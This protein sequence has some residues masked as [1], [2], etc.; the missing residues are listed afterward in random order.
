MGRRACIVG[1]GETEFVRDSDRTAESFMAEAIALALADA[2]LNAREVQGLAV[3]N[4]HLPDDSAYTAEHLGFELDWVLKGDQGGAA[5]IIS[6]IRARH[7]IEAGYIDIAVCAAGDNRALAREHDVTRPLNDYSRRN[8]V[9]PY[10]YGG[11]N[12][13]FALVQR[14]H[15]HRYGTTAE[16]LGKIAVTFRKHAGLNPNALL[17]DPMT[18][19]DYL[20]SRMISDPI[21]LFD[22]VM[23]CCGGDAVVVAAEDVAER[24]GRAPVYIGRG[25]ERINY[26][27][28]ERLPDKLTMGFKPIAEKMLGPAD[29]ARVD[30]LQCYDDYPIAILMTLEDLG[31]CRKGV[32]GAFV[33]TTDLSFDGDLPM[34]TGGGQLS[35]GQPGL[36]GGYLHVVEAVRQLRGEAG[37]RQVPEARRG[38]VTGIGLLSYHSNV[39]A[40]AAVILEGDAS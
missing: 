8:F 2:G 4:L 37:A 30:F 34:N 7:A 22:C 5:A 16:Q 9:D 28:R 11:P 32:G 26:Q 14:L 25:A 18:I 36:A 10:G 3:T 31:Y 13:L 1:V 12:S 24:L 15:M 19:D 33:E 35:A 40:N 29:R 38:L 27:I 39:A 20:K 6:L 21:R 17:R 23:P